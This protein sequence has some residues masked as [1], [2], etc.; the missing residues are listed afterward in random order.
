MFLKQK[1][2]QRKTYKQ[3]FILL[4]AETFYHL[5]LLNSST[6]KNALPSFWYGQVFWLSDQ[7]SDCNL[8]AKSY[9]NGIFISAVVLKNNT[10][11]STRLQRRDRHGI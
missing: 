4:S 10:I 7:P 8:P 5:A 11:I 6:R 1:R 2:L 3:K 9:H